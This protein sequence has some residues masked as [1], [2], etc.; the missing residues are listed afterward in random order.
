MT[1][2][3]SV[4]SGSLGDIFW[5]LPAWITYAAGYDVGGNIYVANPTDTAKEYALM[6][7][8]VRNG[9]TLSEEALPVFGYTWFTVEPGDFINLKGAIRFNDSDA[10][11]MVQLIE[12]ESGEATDSVTTRLVSTS[13]SAAFPPGWPDTSGASDWS[14]LLKTLL[15]FLMMVILGIVMISAFKAKDEKVSKPV[16]KAYAG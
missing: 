13:N 3:V 6:A 7:K 15:P 11:L 10:D 16:G 14:T 2:Q 12:K 8:L 5:D 1:T 4:M 9:Q